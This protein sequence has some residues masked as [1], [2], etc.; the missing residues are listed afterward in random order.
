[1]TRLDTA[2]SAPEARVHALESQHREATRLLDEL[3]ARDALKTQFLANISHDLRTPLTAIITHAEILR[4]LREALAGRTALI[5][6]HRISAIRDATWIIV[7]EDGRI[8][9]QGTHEELL[10]RDGRSLALYGD[11]AAAAA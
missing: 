2:T 9:E 5:A 3:Q 6:S 8:V 10:A 7:L 4:G 1:M 11:W